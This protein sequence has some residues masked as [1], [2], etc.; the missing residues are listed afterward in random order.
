MTT[1]RTHP[2]RHTALRDA[3][4]RA[5]GWGPISWPP[6]LGLAA[7]LIAAYIV[8]GLLRDRLGVPV[9]QVVDAAA[10]AMVA[11]PVWLLVQ[12]PGVRAAYDVITWLNGWEAERWQDEIG[13]RLTAVPRATPAILDRLPDTMGLRPLRVELLAVRGELDEARERL[14]QL[15]AD[16]PWQRFERAALAEW[17]AWWAGEPDLREPMR[18]ALPAMEGDERHIA[19]RALVAAA[20]ARRAAVSGG[21][22]IAPLAAL[23]GALGDRAGRYAFGYRTGVIV[24]VIMMSIVACIVISVAA[25]VVR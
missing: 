16:T 25:G 22:A 10:F 12:R 2:D 18:S 15:P 20:D 19:A 21:D 7:G 9:R 17:I 3:F 6:T 8:D 13:R 11:A 5:Q 1:S 4:R 23:R 24:M 14:E